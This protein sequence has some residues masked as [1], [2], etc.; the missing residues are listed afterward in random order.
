MSTKI[1]SSVNPKTTSG[2]DGGGRDHEL[3]VTWKTHD[4]RQLGFDYGGSLHF[5]LCADF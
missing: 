3:K 1:P 5:F 2:K 4:L